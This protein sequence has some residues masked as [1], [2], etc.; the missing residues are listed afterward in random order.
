MNICLIILAVFL[1]TASALMI[2]HL[3]HAPVGEET[4]EGFRET[5]PLGA[6]G[7]RVRR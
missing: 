5:S 6:K 2:Y 1:V 4:P 7:K 3:V